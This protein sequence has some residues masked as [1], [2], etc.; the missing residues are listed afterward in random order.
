[1]DRFQ[2]SILEYLGKIGQGVLVLV[3][4]IYEG[5]YYEATYFYTSEQIVLTAPQELEE[6]LGCKITEDKDYPLLIKDLI[7]K[8]VPFKEIYNRIDEVDF[9]RWV[10]E[11]ES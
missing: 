10:P 1:M 3:S 11:E 9:N 6:K 4:I 5:E 2:S 8:V 7:K